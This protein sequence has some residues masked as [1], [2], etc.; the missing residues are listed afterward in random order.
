MTADA[1]RTLATRQWEHASAVRG[2]RVRLM[3]PFRPP[4]LAS[5]LLARATIAR[6]T[7]Y[8]FVSTYGAITHVPICQH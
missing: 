2:P 3:A 1:R 4:R 8:A 6:Y 7:N 5:Q